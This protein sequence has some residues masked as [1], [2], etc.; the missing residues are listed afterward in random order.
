[1]G[2]IKLIAIIG[3]A[4]FGIMNS[5][6]E[7]RDKNN[8]IT[9]F[10]KIGFTG[11]LFMALLVYMLDI[12]SEKEDKKEND[13]LQR[14]LKILKDRN[15]KILDK[16]TYLNLENQNL[17]RNVNSL[18]SLAREQIEIITRLSKDNIDL[19]DKLEIA[20]GKIIDQIT[21]GGSYCYVSFSNFQKGY[22]DLVVVNNGKEPMYNL[23]VR[24]VDLE[25]FMKIEVVQFKDLV[26]N[27]FTIEEI[28][29]NQAVF[30][31]SYKLADNIPLV[32]FNIFFTARNGSFT[33]IQRF[34]KINSS[35]TFATKVTNLMT[36]KKL[37]ERVEKNYPRNKGKNIDWN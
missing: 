21:G 27:T 35:W 29:P 4:L 11:M 20:R 8:K 30:M 2:V 14:E 7:F 34:Q 36:N 19:A 37:Y 1:M 18:D 5:Y 26:Q 6:V 33:Q 10:G 9:L 17:K 3:T 28:S 24:I 25:K 22:G 15:N 23:S 31:G 32:K 16:T 12:H 13:L